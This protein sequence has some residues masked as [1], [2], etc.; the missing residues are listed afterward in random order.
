M[1]KEGVAAM[2][3]GLEG[4]NW[5]VEKLPKEGSPSLGQVTVLS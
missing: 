5:T 1:I 4:S 3:F 2:S